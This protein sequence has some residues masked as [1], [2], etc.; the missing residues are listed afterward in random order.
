MYGGEVEDLRP[1]D[2]LSKEE[3]RF[4]T[5]SV[6]LRLT[7]LKGYSEKLPDH[8]T[9]CIIKLSTDNDYPSR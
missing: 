2:K 1:V 8:H 7:P 5:T 4:L 9:M 3:L 6:R